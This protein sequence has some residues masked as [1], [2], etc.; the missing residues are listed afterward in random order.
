[1]TNNQ[2]AMSLTFICVTAGVG[3]LAHLIFDAMK[4]GVFPS[5]YQHLHRN[6]QPAS[7][8]SNV[9]FHAFAIALL[10]AIGCYAIWRLATE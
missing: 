5:R 8:W 3:L 7:F 6:R 10:L 1:M 2:I 4:S 9:V